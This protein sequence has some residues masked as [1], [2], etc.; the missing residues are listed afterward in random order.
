M[1][2]GGMMTLGWYTPGA[3][4]SL[5]TFEELPPSTHRKSDHGQYYATKDFHDPVKNRRILWGWGV[6][7][8]N[9]RRPTLPS[10]ALQTAT[11]RINCQSKKEKGTQCA[12]INPVR[13]RAHICRLIP[14]Y[15]LYSTKH[16]NPFSGAT[17]T[18]AQSL[19]REVTWNPELQ[20]LCYS[21]LDEQAS[22]RTNKLPVAGTPNTKVGLA[23]LRAQAAPHV[24]VI[25][26]GWPAGAGNQ[27]EIDVSSDA[28]LFI[29]ASLSCINI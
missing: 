11:F 1:A 21:P 4:K 14:P 27:S 24:H 7:P 2:F 13:K 9:V 22:L 18:K 6:P 19:P 29:S 3:P 15:S 12:H 28:A 26:E 20:Q 23:T 10:F 8:L 5:G 25:S 16:N 17:I